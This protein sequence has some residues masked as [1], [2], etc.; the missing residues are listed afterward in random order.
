MNHETKKWSVVA[1]ALLLGA[2]SLLALGCVGYGYGHHRG[3]RPRCD[4]GGTYHHDDHR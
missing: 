2:V 4:D 1:V 3:D